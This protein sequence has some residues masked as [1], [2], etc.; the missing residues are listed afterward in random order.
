MRKQDTPGN[1]H[2]LI[3]SK[4]YKGL[5]THDTKQEIINV[6]TRQRGTQDRNHGISKHEDQTYMEKEQDIWKKPKLRN[7]VQ[8]KND[9][10]T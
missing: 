6:H 4:N 8:F 7:D 1:N 3:N 2:E 9:Y 5:Q 10:V